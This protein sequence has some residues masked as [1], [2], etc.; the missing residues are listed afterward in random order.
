MLEPDAR[1]PSLADIGRARCS[2]QEAEGGAAA[3]PGQ[4]AAGRRCWRW[5]GGF[6]EDPDVHGILVQL[7]LPKHLDEQVGFA[8]AT[9]ATP[10]GPPGTLASRPGRAGPAAA[11]PL[12]V[13]A[14]VAVVVVVLEAEDAVLGTISLQKDVDGFHSI[15][16]GRLA[17]KGHEPLFAPCTL[18]GCIELLDK[19]PL[20]N[21]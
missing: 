13:V 11:T 19:S 2:V 20:H 21:A 12:A 14:V 8:A 18:L 3:A 7:P 5:C 6:N 15:N 4:G 1:T 16:I 17:M 9:P 10:P